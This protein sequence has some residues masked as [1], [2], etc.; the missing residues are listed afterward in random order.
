MKLTAVVDN[1]STDV[2]NV[3]LRSNLKN[4]TRWSTP[5]TVYSAGLGAAVTVSHDLQAVPNTIAVEPLVDSRWWADQDDMRTW[6][7][8]TVTLHTSH[9]G[10]FVVRVGFQ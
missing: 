8:T 3:A 4:V 9:A 7:A 10:Q 2:I 6:N 5:V 1:P